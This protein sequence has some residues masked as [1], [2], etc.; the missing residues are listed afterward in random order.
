MTLALDTSGL[1][2]RYRREGGT[3]EVLVAMDRDPQWVVS[4]IART[5]AELALCVGLTPADRAG[6]VERLRA[7]LDRCLVVPVD[8]ECLARAADIG[9]EHGVR[10][11]DALHLAAA[12][13]LPRPV[14][15][16]T[17]DRRQA[18]AARRLGLAVAGID[19]DPTGDA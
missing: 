17:F 13:R 8:P 12:D 15:F 5:E 11:L 16:L 6:A 1:V 9:C 19:E 2:K 4:A 18:A 3:D 14:T 10:T 7:D